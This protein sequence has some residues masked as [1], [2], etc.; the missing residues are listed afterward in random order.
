[1]VMGYYQFGCGDGHLPERRTQ[2]IARKHGAELVNYVEPGNGRKRHWFNTENL[3][4]P[5]DEQVATAVLDE[6]RATG[7]IPTKVA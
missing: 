2:R 3:G 5:H 1:M 4:S 6:L 7:I